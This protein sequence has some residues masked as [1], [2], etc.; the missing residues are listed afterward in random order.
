MDPWRLATKAQRRI[1]VVAGLALASC[2]LA[3]LAGLGSA[4]IQ[5]ISAAVER[6]A[7]VPTVERPG[8]SLITSPAPTDTPQADAPQ[9][10]VLASADP[11]DV[12]VPEAADSSVM[13]KVAETTAHLSNYEP[14]SLFEISLS[15]PSQVLPPEEPPAELAMVSPTDPVPDNAPPSIGI[16]EINEEC[17]VAEICIDRYLWALYERA[18]KIDAIKVHERRKVTIKRK[19]K[20]VTVTRTFT[21]RV[22]EDFTWKDPKAAERAGMSMM[23]YVIGGMDRKF[24]LKLFHTLHAAEQ[25]GLHPGITS[26]FRDDYRQSIA[27]GLK[28]AT[29]RSYHG[30]SL[31]GGYGR[32]VAAD[33]VSVKGATRAQRW[34]ST[35]KLWKWIDERGKDFGIGRPYLD[36]DP[37]HVAPIDGQE[38]VSRRGGAKTQVAEAKTKKVAEVKSKKVAE[39]K[40]KKGSRLA[41]RDV[42]GKA[43]QAKTAKTAKTAKLARTM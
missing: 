7:A 43:K 17:L 8:P 11:G 5:Q 29:D 22:D 41:A 12:V 32:G 4:P 9:R 1:N 15:D 14:I 25:A 27:S 13:R 19:G 18:P 35:E 6:T 38:Y 3:W 24:K 2:G 34:V 16:L 26:A 42:R 31:R 33:I 36:R 40:S 37:P 21:K 28:A 30:G 20:M 10:V 39:A 23:D